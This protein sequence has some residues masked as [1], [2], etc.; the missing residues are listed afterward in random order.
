MKAKLSARR[1][2]FSVFY[3]P[4]MKRFYGLGVKSYRAAVQKILDENDGEWSAVLD[5]THRSHKISL[6][7][8]NNVMVPN[9]EYFTTPTIPR[10]VQTYK[11]ENRRS[12]Q[13]SLFNNTE[14][15]C[16]YLINGRRIAGNVVGRGNI[17]R[18]P[19]ITVKNP[20]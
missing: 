17:S 13:L 1:K 4:T 2:L 18:I 8:I 10:I 11:A 14:N 5:T 19:V 20:D 3:S 16:M 15:S 9:L 12:V 7:A 6:W